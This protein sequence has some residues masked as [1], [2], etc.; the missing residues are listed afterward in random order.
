M[1]VSHD[2]D[3]RKTELEE[4]GRKRELEAER[5]ERER[6]GRLEQRGSTASSRMLRHF[7]KPAK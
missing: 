5:A 6:Q 3:E 4:E 2:E 1:A 7:S